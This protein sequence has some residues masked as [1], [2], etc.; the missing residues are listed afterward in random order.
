M[1]DVEIQDIEK[2]IKAI[3]NIAIMLTGTTEFVCKGTILKGF[4]KD[5]EVNLKRLETDIDTF[6]K[7]FPGKFPETLEPDSSLSRIRDIAIKLKGDNA[8]IEAK[9]RSGDLGNDLNIGAMEL[10]GIVKDTLDTL[11][12]K[13]SGYTFTNKIADYVGRVKSFLIDLFPLVSNIG[14][15]ILIAILAAVLSFVYLFLTM[16]SEKALRDSIK[17]DQDYIKGQKDAI[18]RQRQE[19]KEIRES[20]KSLE[21][22]EL[23]REDKIRFLN[24]S[25][26]E[27]E[28][29]DFI[30]KTV[31]SIEKRKREIA[32]KNKR[33]AELRK[34]SFL[35][36][37][38]GD[39]LKIPHFMKR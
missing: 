36:R 18:R 16:E 7:R 17:N 34:K 25:S 24:L 3:Q 13:V 4:S 38:L 10:K 35:Q 31:I 22:K 15:I 27:R 32:E 39:R 6:K 12:G 1:P 37:L 2:A 5:I 30:D 21:K 20:I 28:I 8:N 23:I 29:K 9:C 11:N 19:Y 14:K 33:L 26:K